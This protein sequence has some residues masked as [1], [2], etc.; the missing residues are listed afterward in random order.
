[1]LQISGSEMLQ[2]KIY[3]ENAA[4]TH[5]KMIPE[6]YIVQA[7][8]LKVYASGAEFWTQR[9]LIR[10][11]KILQA[12]PSETLYKKNYSENAKVSQM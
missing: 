3:S 2:K 1:M 9:T 11:L 5:F 6:P 4:M 8:S 7:V 12:I 10:L